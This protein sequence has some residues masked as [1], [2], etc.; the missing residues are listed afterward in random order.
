M[1][2]HI[3]AIFHNFEPFSKYRRVETDFIDTHAHAHARTGCLRYLY[4]RFKMKESGFY[5]KWF[6]QTKFI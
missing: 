1:I 6:S 2:E 3:S 4:I 5:Q